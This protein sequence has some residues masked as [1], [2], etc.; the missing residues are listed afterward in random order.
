LVGEN[1]P[2][3]TVLGDKGRISV[4]RMRPGSQRRPRPERSGPA[5]VSEVAVKKGQRTVVSSCRLDDLGEGE[6]LV[7]TASLKT[8]AAKL[9]YPTRISTRLFLADDPAQEQPGGHAAS[10][11][12]LRGVI[13]ARNG[14]NCLPNHPHCTTRKVGVARLTKTPSG[15]L[16]VN[17]VGDSGDPTHRGQS[18]DT[19]EVLP[20][21]GIEVVRYP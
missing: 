19:L 6:Q 5:A 4:V 12:A 21:A 3:G 17:M 10:V 13:T 7:V 8:S 9:G 16:Y 18:G 11:A 20:G 14:F 1:E 15:P 2:D